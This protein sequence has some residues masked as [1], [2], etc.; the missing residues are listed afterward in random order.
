[1]FSFIIWLII[2]GLA[3]YFAGQFMG[4]RRPYGIPGDVGLGI[5]GSIVGGWLLSLVGFSG[6]GIIATMITAFLGATLLIWGAR[7]LKKV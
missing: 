7:K 5:V 4:A 1:M 3:G 6:S 2:G